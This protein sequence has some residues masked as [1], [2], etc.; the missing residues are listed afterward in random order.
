MLSCNVQEVKQE[1]PSES[2]WGPPPPGA[3]AA[4]YSS[5][6]PFAEPPHQSYAPPPYA[7]QLQVSVINIVLHLA[8]VHGAGLPRM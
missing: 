6:A 7:G 4:A 1:R 5:S 2:K 8:F 3:P